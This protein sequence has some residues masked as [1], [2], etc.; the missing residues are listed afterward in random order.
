MTEFDAD[1]RWRLCVEQRSPRRSIRARVGRVILA[2]AFGAALIAV[3]GVG[4]GLAQQPR[5]AIEAYGA[6]AEDFAFDAADTDGDDKI[7]EAE[8]ARDAAAGFSGLDADRSGT[9]TSGELEAHDPARFARVDK[10][11]DGRLS[12]KEVMAHKSRAF[13]EADKDK[14]GY[15][16]FKEMRDAVAAEVGE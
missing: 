3:A 16:S 11:G 4:P 9:L 12:F 15:L 1:E 14:D 8:L 6:A 13:N 10:N 7:S 2:S 5:S